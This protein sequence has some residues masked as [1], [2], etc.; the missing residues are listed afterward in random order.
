MNLLTRLKS[1][2]TSDI[3]DLHPDPGPDVHQV[4]RRT[5]LITIVGPILL[6]LSAELVLHYLGVAD[7]LLDVPTTKATPDRISVTPDRISQQIHPNP[8]NSTMTH[9]SIDPLE[10]S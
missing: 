8:P 6:L 10:L 7:P 2:S 9:L 5:I 4:F 3:D 1:R